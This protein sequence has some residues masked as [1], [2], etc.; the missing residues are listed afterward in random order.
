[1]RLSDVSLAA[2]AFTLWVPGT[3]FAQA[4][5]SVVPCCRSGPVRENVFRDAR[6]PSAAAP[7]DRLLFRPMTTVNE[8]LTGS[9]DRTQ[10]P[11]KPWRRNTVVGAA[12]GRL[13]GIAWGVWLLRPEGA[14]GDP[15][16]LVG[17]STALGAAAGALGGLVWTALR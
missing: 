6:E 5:P 13:V 3:A 14:I 8:L 11:G 17:Y 9:A 16:I 2:V 7:V 12:I 15:K 1:M 10:D 4:E